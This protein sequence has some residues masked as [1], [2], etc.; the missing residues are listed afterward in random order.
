MHM[1]F[2]ATLLESFAPTVPVLSRFLERLYD[3]VG[4]LT[5]K[6]AFFCSPELT[7]CCV[8]TASFVH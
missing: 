7:L 2:R 1:N 8:P 3:L 4:S 5:E 6:T